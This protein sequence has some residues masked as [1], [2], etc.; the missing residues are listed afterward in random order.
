MPTDPGSWTIRE[1][2]E[3]L[4]LPSPFGDEAFEEF[5]SRFGRRFKK[6]VSGISST[7]YRMDFD[8]ILEW[9]YVYLYDKRKIGYM[10][11]AILDQPEDTSENS[12][13]KIANKYL[14]K[15]LISAREDFRAEQR[16]HLPTK[17]DAPASGGQRIDWD[18]PTFISQHTEGLSTGI[19]VNRD[20][21][22]SEEKKPFIKVLQQLKPRDRVITAM[23]HYGLAGELLLD[24]SDWQFI[25]DLTGKGRNELEALIT[26]EISSHS[27]RVK[28]PIS[29]AFISKLM[30]ESQANV[31]KIVQ[32]SRDQL[33]D[34]LGEG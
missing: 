4:I 7:K 5:Q 11:K 14:T 17:E 31:H 21:L 24:E 3:R 22:D 30:G 20:E 29:A 28:Y 15:V 8:E 23:M 9:F 1:L 6:A 2:F 26:D 25:S 13:E 12:L 18:G 27:K 19:S 33:R 10:A 32:R 34:E 16:E